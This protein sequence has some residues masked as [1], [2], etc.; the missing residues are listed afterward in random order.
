[1]NLIQS[2]LQERRL[3]DVPQL[4]ELQQE[5]LDA[6]LTFYQGA[7][8]HSADPDP[9]VRL[10]TAIA[11]Q[12]AGV[13]QKTLGR[14]EAAAENF[15]LALDLIDGLPSPV[16]DTQEA[17]EV[18]VVSFNGLGL[19]AQDALRWDEAER[20]HQAALGI[21][22]RLLLAAPDHPTWQNRLAESEHNLAVVYQLTNRRPDAEPHYD[23]A[24]AIRTQLVDQHPEEKRY[25]FLLADDLINQAL[26]YQH[27]QR[28]AE[29]TQTYEKAEPLLRLLIKRYPPGGDYAL[30]LAILQ[31]N[32]SYLLRT[33]K[34]NQAALE[35]LNEAVDLAEAVLKQEPRHATARSCAFNALRARAKLFELLE[36]YP[37]A[38][39]D[40]DRVLELNTN[41]NPWEFRV[42][43]ALTLALRR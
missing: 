40:W 29:A 9:Q 10:D 6:T 18:R 20:H 30:S 4:K 17:Q 3:E 1:M 15:S 2:R 35:R 8:A 28:L 37:E 25:Q 5:L 11:C 13:I 14:T 34:K 38:V 42:Q 12:Q 36:R 23:R 32:W 24:I 43:R 19:L 27:T 26:I 31:V 22:G 16:R 41:P 33:E 21:S 39:P 7:L